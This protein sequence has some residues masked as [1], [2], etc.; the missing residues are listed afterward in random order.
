MA[1]SQLE[2][3]QWQFGLAWRLAEYHLPALTDEACLWEPIPHCWTVRQS[4][5]GKWRPDWTE[6][7]PDPPPATTIGWA[8]WHLIWWWS[9]ALREI[10]N[11]PA[12]AREDVLWPGSAEGVQLQ[13]KALSREWEAT[14]AGLQESEMEKPFAHPWA[15][16]RPLRIALAWANAELMKNVAEIGYVRLLFEASWTRK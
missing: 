15:E 16:P 14:L 11:E 2:T 9:A 13:L 4:P 7:E 12:V 6:V 10:R 3:L 1:S 5:D 8:S